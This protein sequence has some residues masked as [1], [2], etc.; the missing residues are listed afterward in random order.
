MLSEGKINKTVI[1]NSIFPIMI[2]TMKSPHEI[3]VE[4]KY[5]KLMIQVKSR[6]WLIKPLK[7]YPK[8]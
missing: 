8:K 4:N 5:F 6:I 3:A 1:E 2:K 7:K